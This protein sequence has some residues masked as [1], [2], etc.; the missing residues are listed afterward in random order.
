MGIAV[1][2]RIFIKLLP[3]PILMLEFALVVNAHCRQIR[4]IGEFASWANLHSILCFFF[5][6]SSKFYREN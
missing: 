6:H 4:V 3:S 1:T 5:L 2:L